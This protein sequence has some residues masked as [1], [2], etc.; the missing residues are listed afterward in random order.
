V[1]K[2]VILVLATVSLAGCALPP[3]TAA[4]TPTPHPA[5]SF[6]AQANAARE[7]ASPDPNWDY[8]QTVSIKAQGF[9]PADLVSICCQPVVFKNLT[10]APV[11]VVFDHQLVNSGPIAP[12]SSFTWTPPN[13]ESVVFHAVEHPEWTHGKVQVN[14]SFES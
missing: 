12:G 8:G 13:V 6:D 10:E 3:E 11:T 14:Q 1:K 9:L 5:K 7:A 4:T 2:A